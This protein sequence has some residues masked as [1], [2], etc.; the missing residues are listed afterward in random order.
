MAKI[1]KDSINKG[2][3]IDDSVV[4]DKKVDLRGGKGKVAKV[5][6]VNNKFLLVN[7]GDANSP[8]EDSDI[9]DIEEKLI[10]F[11]NE[12]GIK[13]PAFITHHA[14]SVSVVE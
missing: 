9:K 1:N 6:N 5:Q 3:I 13:L 12:N 2:S 11:L 8:A 14:V 10:T 7:V 4:E